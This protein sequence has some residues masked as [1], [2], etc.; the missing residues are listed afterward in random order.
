MFLPLYVVLSSAIFI[1]VV[2]VGIAYAGIGAKEERPLAV[3]RW[4]LVSVG[5]ILL[6]LATLGA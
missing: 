4:G 1:A 2:C 5:L 3:I 6:A